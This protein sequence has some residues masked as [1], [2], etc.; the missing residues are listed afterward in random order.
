MKN[1]VVLGILIALLVTLTACGDNSG[2]SS[3]SESAIL[4]DDY[5]DALPVTAQLAVGTL[6]LEGTENAVTTEQAGD[7][8]TNW[9]M[10]QALQSSG[11]AAQAEL[12]VVVN[13]VEGA[14]TAE[15][16]AAIKEMK[17]TT[18]NIAELAQEQGLGRGLAGGG[19]AG[20]F[21]P[22]AGVSPGGGAGGGFGRGQELNPEE[23]EAAMAERMNQLAG[24]ASINMVISL[25]EARAEGEE[26]AAATPNQD[27]ALQ[28]TLLTAIAEATGLDQQELVAQAREGTTA[29][30]IVQASGVDLDEIVAQIVT[31]ET[32]RVKQTV[33]NG[34]LTQ[35]DA[36]D[37]LADLETRI[38]ELLTQPLQFGG[39]GAFGDSS[40]QP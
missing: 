18:D 17:L 5:A 21:R 32:E 1:T 2:E 6:L 9:Q 8:L 37:L 28:R 14:M 12:D 36:D 24:T 15:Q 20:G 27:F 33:S 23:M 35:A 40:G 26:W 10:L 39:R 3:A 4:N 22:P 19:Q 31:A 25:L 30:Q 38:N 13:Q 29:A 7:L 16:L 34:T 11:T